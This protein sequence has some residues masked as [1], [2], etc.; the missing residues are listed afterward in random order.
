MTPAPKKQT[1]T[2]PQ[3]DLRFRTI[4]AEVSNGIACVLCGH[5]FSISPSLSVE[6]RANALAGTVS[7]DSAGPNGRS[8]RKPGHHDS[9]VLAEALEL[10]QQTQSPKTSGPTQSDRS[11]GST[12]ESCPGSSLGSCP[13]CNRHVP[14]APHP[15]LGQ[16]PRDCVYCGTNLRTGKPPKKSNETYVINRVAW[17]IDRWLNLRG[18]SAMASGGGAEVVGAGGPYHVGLG[19]HLGV[20]GVF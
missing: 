17:D 13:G 9:T 8:K 6:Q 15:T 2:C 20:R 16:T 14:Q 18:D 7:R 5:T 10:E 12:P 4:A 3:C 11:P 1:V 19:G